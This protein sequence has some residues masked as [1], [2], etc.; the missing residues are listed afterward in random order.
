MNLE[1]LDR[2]LLFRLDG[3]R[4]GGTVI[5]ANWLQE[6]RI[7]ALNNGYTEVAKLIRRQRKD[8]LTRT[9]LSTDGTVFIQGFQYAT[10]S[11]Q[12]RAGT[13]AYTL[14]PDFLELRSLRVLTTNKEHL[15][16]DLRDANHED[17]RQARRVV[18]TAGTLRDRFVV[19][20]TGERTMTVAPTVQETLDLEVT[21]AA[22]LESLVRYTVGT[23]HVQ[24][25]LNLVTS[26]SATADWTER[27]GGIRAG[28]ELLVGS[29]TA[30]PVANLEARYH[31]VAT[32][33]GAG[34]SLSLE[35]TYLGTT[36]YGV[37]YTL[38]S[39][40]QF[41]EDWHFAIAEY[42]VYV[43]LAKS[44]EEGNAVAAEEAWKNWERIAKALVPESAQRQTSDVEPVE[45]WL[46]D[47]W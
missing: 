14:P 5:T 40:P 33:A 30:A 10:G 46:P 22:Q 27:G 26:A 6:E 2:Y 34:T 7:Q 44:V 28:D 15:L 45:D 39:V 42:A 31:K 25:G 24:N 38:A 35:D 1:T 16:F 36:A 37:L 3:I 8:H 47:M 19:A 4:Q 32:V 29:T 18:T 43:L 17:F 20:I 9:R 21:Y 11:M 23:L 13:A 41:H 12:L